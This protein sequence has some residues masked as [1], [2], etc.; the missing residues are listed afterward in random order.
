[1][2]EESQH[3]YSFPRGSRL[4]K[5]SA[6]E[7]V[8]NTGRRHFSTQFTAFY[9]LT[10]ASTENES[11][12]RVGLTVGRALGGA[13]DRNRMKRR[14]R[15]A[16]RL[17]LPELNQRLRERK[18]A[19]EIVINPKKV[20]LTADFAKLDAEVARAFAAIGAAKLESKA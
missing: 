15:N 12:P 13:V 14:M 10:P 19:A 3:E 18:L 20:S 1:M 9:V 17:H 5:H 16:V 6:F 7:A 4:L 11:Q 2:R 8:Y